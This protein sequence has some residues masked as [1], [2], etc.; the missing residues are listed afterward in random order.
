VRGVCDAPA[1]FISISSSSVSRG[2]WARLVAIESSTTSPAAIAE[3]VGLAL[4]RGPYCN[5]VASKQLVD[6]G[7]FCSPE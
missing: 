6:G 4:D 2:R 3:R 5:G 1:L 7:S